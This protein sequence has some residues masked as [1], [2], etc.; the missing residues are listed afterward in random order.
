MSADIENVFWAMVLQVVCLMGIG[1]HAL[2]VDKNDW[3]RHQGD[4]RSRE[5]RTK[6]RKFSQAGLGIRRRRLS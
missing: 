3:P 5:F 6:N 4:A 1:P 2:S